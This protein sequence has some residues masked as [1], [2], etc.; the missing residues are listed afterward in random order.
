MPLPAGA[1]AKVIVNISDAS[2]GS[3]WLSTGLTIDGPAKLFIRDF[4]VRKGSDASCG[5]PGCKADWGIRKLHEEARLFAVIARIGGGPPFHVPGDMAIPRP[6]KPGE[7]LVTVNH[8]LPTPFTSRNT[9]SGVRGGF[10]LT[11]ER[12]GK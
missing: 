9:L 6:D 4:N 7:L 10:V 12:R 1:A 11:I 2:S 3:P 8:Y 5:L